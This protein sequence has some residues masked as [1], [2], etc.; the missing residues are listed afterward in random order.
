MSVTSHPDVAQ[1]I[2]AYE[3][4]AGVRWL[5]AVRALGLARWEV[6]EFSEDGGRR[7]IEELAGDGESEASALALA[8]D[9]LEQHATR[10]G[11]PG[12]QA[13]GRPAAAAAGRGRA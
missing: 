2:G 6:C 11:T 7:V 8:R 5:V 10:P 9:Y 12:E 1:A 3:D 13:T 4:R